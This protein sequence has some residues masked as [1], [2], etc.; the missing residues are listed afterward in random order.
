M[1]GLQDRR[2]ALRAEYKGWIYSATLRKSGQI[3]YDGK[4]FDSPTA[5][6]KTITKRRVNGWQFWKYRDPRKGWVALAQLRR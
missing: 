4:I 1:A 3:S 2:R 6:A 5:A